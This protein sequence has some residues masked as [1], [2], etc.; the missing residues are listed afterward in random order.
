MEHPKNRESKSKENK[1]ESQNWMDL[2][3]VIKIMQALEA[4]I[5]TY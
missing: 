1:D 4:P 2:H 3:I 5:C